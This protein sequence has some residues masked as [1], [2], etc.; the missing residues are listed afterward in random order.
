M[1]LTKWV[2]EMTESIFSLLAYSLDLKGL[3]SFL[4]FF[5]FS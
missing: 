4:F 2:G 3:L 5:L 1:L